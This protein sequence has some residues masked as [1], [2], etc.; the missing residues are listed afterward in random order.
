MTDRNYETQVLGWDA[1]GAIVFNDVV[2]TENSAELEGGC[3]YGVG[4]GIINHGTVMIDNAGDSGG[5]ICER[6][7][8]QSG[9]LMLLLTRTGME[10]L[11]R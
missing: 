8:S 9:S 10:I 3:F 2:C 6:K 4:A 1:N 11:N 5:A 7:R